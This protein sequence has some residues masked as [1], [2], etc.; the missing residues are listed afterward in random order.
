MNPQIVKQLENIKDANTDKLVS[1]VT[2]KLEKVA[3]DYYA[4]TVFENQAN[5]NLRADYFDCQ[6][7]G[8]YKPLLWNNSLIFIPGNDACVVA[9]AKDQGVALGLVLLDYITKEVKIAVVV[10]KADAEYS[11]TATVYS[12]ETKAFVT[13]E[14]KL[15]CADFKALLNLFSSKL[16]EDIAKFND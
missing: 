15:A 14:T 10:D 4:S 7:V 9:S 6:I 13:T 12:K 1:L 3:E 11:Y 2:G 16:G 5:Y 8:K